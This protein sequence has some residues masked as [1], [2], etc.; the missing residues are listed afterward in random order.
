[1]D[2][3]LI[4]VFFSLSS[5]IG[6]EKITDGYVIGLNGQRIIKVYVSRR[7][8]IKEIIAIYRNMEIKERR[9]DVYKWDEVGKMLVV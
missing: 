8:Y 7:C 6:T 4:P 9:R 5:P 2:L 3:E 1:M